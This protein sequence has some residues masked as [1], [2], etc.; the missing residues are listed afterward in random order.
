MYGIRHI[1]L[2]KQFINTY[3]SMNLLPNLGVYPKIRRKANLKREVT[4]GNP[5]NQKNATTIPIISLHK[6]VEQTNKA[7]YV[8]RDKG[9][10]KSF[11]F[12]NASTSTL[13][14]CD[15]S[16]YPEDDL[17]FPVGNSWS[18]MEVHPF[19]R[20]GSGHDSLHVSGCQT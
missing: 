20:F 1:H 9:P 18:T 12:S 15:P 11:E 3:R 8:D 7:K 17:Q 10:A 19:V 16:R 14:F 4:L 2:F 5:M 13:G 6:Q